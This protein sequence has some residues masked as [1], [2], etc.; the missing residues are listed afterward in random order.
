MSKNSLPTTARKAV[1]EANLT[2]LDKVVSYVGWHILELLGVI[3]VVVLA[4]IFTG[5]LLWLALV[6][7][8][9]AVYGDVELHLNNKGERERR[10]VEAARARKAAEDD[11][12]I[13]L[14][15]LQDEAASPAAEPTKPA[16]EKGAQSA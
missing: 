12:A 11:V 10:A 15:A 13:D 1:N 4:S 5:W 14:D 2:G 7:I 8:G 3:G 9:Y 6:P 16:P